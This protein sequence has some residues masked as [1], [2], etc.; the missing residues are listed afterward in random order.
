M[1]PAGGSGDAKFSVQNSAGAM[2]NFWGPHL[3]VMVDVSIRVFPSAFTQL[4]DGAHAFGTC[5]P[6]GGDGPVDERLNGETWKPKKNCAC[7]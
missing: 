1:T 5:Q 7:S 3:V 6:G 2:P 4:A